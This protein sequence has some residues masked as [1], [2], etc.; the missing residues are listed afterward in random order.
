M[1][2]FNILEEGERGSQQNAQGAPLPG[3][4]AKQHRREARGECQRRAGRGRAGGRVWHRLA[5]AAPDTATVSKRALQLPEMPEIL[6]GG[7]VQ[8]HGAVCKRLLGKGRGWER[9]GR[10]AASSALGGMSHLTI[11]QGNASL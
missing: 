10:G 8:A 4:P 11:S 3:A 1:V 5:L 7:V 9:R 2:P 6:L